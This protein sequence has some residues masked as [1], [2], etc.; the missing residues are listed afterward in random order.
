MP[1]APKPRGSLDKS[2]SSTGY[3]EK[4]GLVALFRQISIPV[5]KFL[6]IFSHEPFFVSFRQIL[7]FSFRQKDKSFSG[8]LFCGLFRTGNIIDL[9]E[10]IGRGRGARLILPTGMNFLKSSRASRVG[11]KRNSRTWPFSEGVSTSPHGA[12]KI[13]TETHRGTKSF[14]KRPNILKITR[15]FFLGVRTRN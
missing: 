1:H 4:L 3:M 11:T 7:F 12:W 14:R 15:M 9:R 8:A 13:D 10:M 2:F 6:L 5:K